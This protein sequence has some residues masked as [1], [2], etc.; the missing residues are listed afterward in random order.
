MQRNDDQSTYLST[1]LKD[2]KALHALKTIWSLVYQPDGFDTFDKN[3]IKLATDTADSYL[4]HPLTRATSFLGLP[5]RCLNN[6]GQQSLSN[7]LKN[8]AGWQEDESDVRRR[9]NRIKTPLAVAWNLATAIPK[10]AINIAKIGT[11]LLPGFACFLLMARAE[12][13]KVNMQNS[14]GLKSAAWGLAYGAATVGSKLFQ[15]IQFVGRAITSPVSGARKAWLLGNQIGGEGVGGKILGGVLAATSIALS[16]AAYAGIA[17]AAAPV[18]IPVL[19]SH[20]PVIASAVS[21]I[22]SNVVAPVLGAVGLS[23][24][25]LAAGL[26]AVGAAA[27]LYL[28]TVAVGLSQGLDGLKEWWHDSRKGAP[29]KAQ[30]QPTVVEGESEENT[31]GCLDFFVST[32]GFLHKNGVNVSHD[33]ARTALLQKKSQTNTPVQLSRG[34][35]SAQQKSGNTNTSRNTNGSGY[36]K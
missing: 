25:P 17:I 36:R 22:G 24:T 30:T 14:K 7:I 4:T 23:A 29:K 32:W 19:V 13:A 34:H 31:P 11:E 1:Y 6:E 12:Q 27:G 15:G 26:G 33:Q 8:I 5:N 28:S 16:A 2:T 18:L 3:Y 21:W 35:S 20:A 9:E 10:L